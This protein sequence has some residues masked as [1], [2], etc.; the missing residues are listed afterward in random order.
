MSELTIT[1]R[2]GETFGAYAAFPEGNG[3]APGLLLLNEVFGVNRFMRAIADYW[4]GRASS[5]S[6]RS[7]TG[8]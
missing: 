1:T 7:S 8:A 2:A 4:A 3:P 6:A 5:L